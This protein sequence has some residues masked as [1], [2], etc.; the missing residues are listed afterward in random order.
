MFETL[1]CGESVILDDLP[2]KSIRKKLRHL[3]QSLRMVEEVSCRRSLDRVCLSTEVSFQSYISEFVSLVSAS[4]LTRLLLSESQFHTQLKEH[5]LLGIFF[6]LLVSQKKVGGDREGVKGF[7]KGI[8]IGSTRLAKFVKKMMEKL[9]EE[10]RED[11]RMAS[12][13]QA[14]GVEAVSVVGD[15]EDERAIL[16]KLKNDAQE[17]LKDHMS[18]AKEEECAE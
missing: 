12:L 10:I 18:K 9:T 6:L 16:K 2:D 15:V 5:T 3:L 8:E 17:K 7:R 14:I 11:R 13:S 4:T 1:D